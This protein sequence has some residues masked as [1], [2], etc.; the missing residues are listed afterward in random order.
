MRLHYTPP[1][2][3]VH[4]RPPTE[5]NLRLSRTFFLVVVLSLVFWLPGFVVFTTSAFCLSCVSP[6]K[7][8]IVKAFHPA[9]SMVNPFV[10][11]FRMPMFKD[12][13]KQFW[14]KRRRNKEVKPVHPFGIVLG[15][16]GTLTLQMGHRGN[17]PDI[18][19]TWYRFGDL[20]P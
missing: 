15:K 7:M 1:G 16:R 5:H 9:N 6:T 4:N 3:E 18:A 13:L 14:R 11:S 17:T 20:V 10:Y 19:L 2:L 8:W 12:A